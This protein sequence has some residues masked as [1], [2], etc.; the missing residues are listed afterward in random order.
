MILRLMVLTFGLAA[1]TGIA[2]A[3]IDPSSALLLNS[4]RSGGSPAESSRYTIRPRPETTRKDE[5]RTVRKPREDESP[6]EPVTVNI[7]SGQTVEATPNSSQNLQPLIIRCEEPSTCPPVLVQGGTHQ[8]SQPL[9]RE[10]LRKL[11]LIELSFAPGYLYNNSDS[12]YSY[13][14]YTSST[15]TLT[16]DAN[17]Y[18]SGTFALHGAYTGTLSGHVSDANNGSKNVPASQE[19]FVAGFRWRKFFGVDVAS[20]VLYFSVD[21]YD[22]QFRVP[23]DAVLREKLRS[24]GVRISLDAEIPANQR[25]SWTVGA[26][27]APKLRHAELSTGV[28]FQ[29]G[30]NVDANAVGLSLGGR[31]QFERS[32][33]I[34]WKLS[35]TVE[36]DLFSGQASKADPQSG[37]TP[38]GV[39]VINS[40]TLFEIGYTWSR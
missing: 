1:A 9:V 34:F 18:L 29:S 39:A 33:A 24:T 25:R 30:G 11:N 15:P 31:V 40:F 5:T 10:N 21:Y 16:V 27:L 6:S 12:S 38:Q 4:S 26:S 7:P 32:D 37:L 14:S 17:V 36:K 20:P 35:H 3:Q 19:W 8:P 23:S 28:E 2:N 22:Y 13:R